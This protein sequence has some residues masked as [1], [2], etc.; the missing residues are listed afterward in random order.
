MSDKLLIPVNDACQRLSMSRSFFYSRLV[1]TGKIKL[2]KF[3]RK[4]L[5]AVENLEQFV[6]TE[7]RKVSSNER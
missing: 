6:K 1:S 3:G 7:L 5:V 4:S 2:L